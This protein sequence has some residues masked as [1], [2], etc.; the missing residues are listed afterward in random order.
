MSVFDYRNN[1]LHAE[2]LPVSE[3]AR[4]VGTPCYIYSRQALESA[5][6]AFDEA[7]GQH[8][9][10][11]CF[12]VKANSNLAVLNV[13]AKLGAGFDIVSQGELERV[14]RAGGDPAK[15]VFSG[16]GKLREEMVRALEVGVYCFNVESEAELETLNEVAGE[17]GKVAAVSLRVNPD[18]DAQ[19]HPYISTGLKQNKF[20]IDIDRAIAVFERAAELPH[21]RVSGIDCHIGSQ[22]TTVTPFMDALDRLLERID[23]LAAKGIVVEH[24]DIG[25]GLGVRYRDEQ[26]PAPSEYVGALLRKLGDRKLKVVMEPGRAIAAN[27]GI[28]VTEVQ[29]LKSTE[30]KNF[31]VVDAAM[32]DLIRPSLYS[33]WQDIIAVSPRAGA[34]TASDVVGPVC[35]TGDFLGKDR[36]LCVEPGDLLAVCSAGAYGFVMSSNYNTR[37]R[38]PEVMVDGGQF[39][40]IRRRETYEDQLALESLVP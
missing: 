28:L 10:L 21:I 7:F 8:P 3:I 22:L 23:Q 5:W 38:V 9:H 25:G 16:V 29:L 36:E 27:A 4:A 2:D 1:Q 18:V 14:L 31:V 20:G 37:N 17:T 39:H 6:K 30:V 40:I 33:A 34:A 13:L 11:V 19:T 15:V 35:E 24:L 12:A 32:N 26:P